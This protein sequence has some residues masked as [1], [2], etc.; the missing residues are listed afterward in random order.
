MW[1]KIIDFY[2]GD[3]TKIKYDYYHQAFVKKNGKK[4]YLY[5]ISWRDLG[6]IIRN[7]VLKYETNI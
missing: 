5:P 4:T 7:K 3:P 1:N 2:N 6:K